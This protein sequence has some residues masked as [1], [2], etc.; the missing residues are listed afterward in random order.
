MHHD[1]IYLGH[2]SEPRHHE[3]EKGAIRRF[4]EALGERDPIYFDEQTAI[5]EGYKGLP[6]PPTFAFTLNPSPIPGLEL[7]AAGIIHGE[8]E[9]TF[10]RT[11]C[12]GDIITVRAWV[13]DVKVRKG[14]LGSM[15]LF[16]IM[17]EGVHQNGDNAFLARS[18]L[19]VTEGVE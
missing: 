18:L 14:R 13:E 16:T 7:P 1:P 2:K 12:S 17:R 19:I 4:A 11:I 3:I 15:T 6:A 9:F 5:A 8:Q 10:G